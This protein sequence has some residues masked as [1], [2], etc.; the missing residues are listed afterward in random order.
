MNRWAAELSVKTN[1]EETKR[2]RSELKAKY[3][4]LYASFA[5]IL[6][7]LDP[8]GIN[9]EILYRCQHRFDPPSRL[10]PDSARS[11]RSPHEGSLPASAGCSCASSNSPHGTLIH[12]WPPAPLQ[13]DRG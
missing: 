12:R 2:R 4:A 1:H 11:A 9:F 13:T 7:R 3:S 8:A 6:F 5:E 10:H